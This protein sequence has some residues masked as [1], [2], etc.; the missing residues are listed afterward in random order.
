MLRKYIE[1]LSRTISFC[2][3]K[4]LVD[5]KTFGDVFIQLQRNTSTFKDVDQCCRPSTNFVHFE[6]T[7]SQV[8]EEV[9]TI[10]NWCL[11]KIFLPIFSSL[12]LH[13]LISFSPNFFSAFLIHKYIQIWINIYLYTFLYICT[14]IYKYKNMSVQN[15]SF[16]PLITRIKVKKQNIR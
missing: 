5:T 15:S 16:G 14:H 10:K 13:S 4:T 2:G 1:R 6:H 7:K 9:E 11:T 8:S 3:F 12:L